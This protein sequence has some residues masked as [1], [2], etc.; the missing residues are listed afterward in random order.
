[1]PAKY[2]NR[3]SC[4]AVLVGHYDQLPLN[5]TRSAFPARLLK[6]QFMCSLERARLRNLPA[7]PFS[8][9]HGFFSVEVQ[10][11]WKVQP[12]DSYLGTLEVS[13][14]TNSMKCA[15]SCWLVFWL[16]AII[17][18]FL[19]MPSQLASTNAATIATMSSTNVP[20]GPGVPSAVVSLSLHALDVGWDLL[21]RDSI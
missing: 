20:S 9:L 2:W 3:F 5:T 4:L 13:S 15:G 16:L 14:Y 8:Y 10:Q 17:H 19:I 12:I 7:H 21:L 11:E 18:A 1:M 6:F